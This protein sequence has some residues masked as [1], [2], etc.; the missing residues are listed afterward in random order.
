MKDSKTKQ[1]VLNIEEVDKMISYCATKKR[2]K[3]QM[4][5]HE[6]MKYV[7]D[8]LII[9]YDLSDDKDHTCLFVY[10]RMRDGY[11]LLNNYYDEE[12]NEIYKK[13][14]ERSESKNDASITD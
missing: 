8:K 2:E 11:L 3:N 4:I 5:K 6:D 14:T 13:L 7:E 9:G 10:R 12:A 1:Y